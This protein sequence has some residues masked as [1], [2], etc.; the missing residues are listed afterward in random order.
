M[1]TGLPITLLAAAM[2][3][4]ASP[5]GTAHAVLDHTFRIQC[6]YSHAA[7]DDP[8]VFPKQPGASH[9][10]TFFGNTSTNAFSTYKSLRAS[11]TTCNETAD[12][13]G[14]WVPALYQNGTFVRPQDVAAYYSAAN[15]DPAAIHP[16]PAGLKMVAGDAHAMAPQAPWVTTWACAGAFIPNGQG[17]PWCIGTLSMVILFPDCWDGAHVDSPD[18][19]AHMAYAEPPEGG[20]TRT[21]PKTHPVPVPQIRLEAQYSSSSTLGVIGGPGT[22]LSSGPWYTAHGDF[23]NAWDQSRLETKIRCNINGLGLS[24]AV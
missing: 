6:E 24:C 7:M 18:H 1:R 2:M 13:S 19:K 11:T 17:V 12:A 15:K 14:Y 22:T 23:F 20:S 10:H 5:G 3:A 4:G 9:L 21:C 8:I 16:F